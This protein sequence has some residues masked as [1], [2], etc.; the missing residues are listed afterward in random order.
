MVLIGDLAQGDHGVLV[1][2]NRHGD[3]AA[4]GDGAGAVRGKQNQLEA[5]RN[6]V[7]AIFNSHACHDRAPLLAAGG[8]TWEM[9]PGAGKPAPRRCLFVS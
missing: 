4:V 2:V 8:L 5:V 1:V 9:K 7:H 6:L 3:G